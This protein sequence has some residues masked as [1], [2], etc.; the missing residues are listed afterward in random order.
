MV[1]NRKNDLGETMF[2]IRNFSDLMIN[3]FLLLFIAVFAF[4]ISSLIHTLMNFVLA[5]VFCFKVTEFRVFGLTYEKQRNGKWEYRGNKHNI[6]FMASCII[7]V[8]KCKGMDNDKLTSKEAAFLLTIALADILIAGAGLIGGIYGGLNIKSTFMASVLYW[9]CV[10]LFIFVMI[11]AVISFY[12]VIKVN[13]KNTLGG[14]AQAATGKIRAGIPFEKLDLKPVS[15]LK[16]KKV[17]YMERIVY[18]P[19][20]FAYLDASGRFDLM[21]PAVEEIESLLKTTSNSRPEL[22]VCIT[23]VYYYSCHCISPSKAKDYYNRAGDTLARDTD[24]NGM[25]VKGFYELNCFGNAQKAR[26]CLNNALA[27]IDTFSIGSERDYERVLLAR[28]SD[29]IE[30]F[31]GQ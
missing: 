4:V 19:F 3:P 31:Q 12:V 22:A 15:E 27:K 24:T 16:L 13:S 21:P 7:D 2:A 28:L 20:Y 23:L 17:T 8:D 14:Y 9:F 18:F 26:E 10:S 5:P 11:R 6:G 1:I 29:A 25:R 30:R